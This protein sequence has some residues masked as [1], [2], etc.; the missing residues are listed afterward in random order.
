MP[1]VLDRRTRRKLATHRALA[2]AA[3]QLVMERGLADVTTE[4]I[5]DAAGVSPRTFFNYF[6]CKEEAI[7]GVD[8]SVLTALA[9]E[10]EARPADESPVRAISAVLVAVNDLPDTA[11]RWMVRTELMRRHPELVP[12][13]MAGLVQL[14]AALTGAVARRLG[15][16][17]NVDP[18]PALVVATA[19]AA[20]RSTMEWW[21]DNGRPTP[22]TDALG[23]AFETLDAGMAQRP[24]T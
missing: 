7:V 22:L 14:E 24:T 6:S 2:H 16:D 13:H 5:A 20:L 11:S 3:R 21:H 4:E 9:E 15:V 8:P 10:V 17:P 1:D 18:F 12:R 19:V 23:G